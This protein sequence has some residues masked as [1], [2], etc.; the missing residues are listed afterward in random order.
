MAALLKPYHKKPFRAGVIGA[1]KICVKI[2]LVRWPIT[3]TAKTKRNTVNKEILINKK[4]LFTYKKGL[5]SNKK[6][7][8]TKKKDLLTQKKGLLA[9]TKQTHGKFSWQIATAKSHGKLS[10]QLAAANSHG[11]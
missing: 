7:L 5:L 8:L 3:A 6:D 1:N 2:K 10:R 4:V 11:K 9:C